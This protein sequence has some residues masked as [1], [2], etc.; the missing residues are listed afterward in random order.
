MKS[1]CSLCAIILK[2]VARNRGMAKAGREIALIVSTI[3]R[4]FPFSSGPLLFLLLV[5]R[6]REEKAPAAKS[7]Y[8]HTGQRED[9]AR[10]ERGRERFSGVN[11]SDLESDC[12]WL[13]SWEPA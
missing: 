5:C 1:T 4:F 12:W 9:T 3:A 7:T 10:K 2:L 6:C 8:L 11:E 13:S